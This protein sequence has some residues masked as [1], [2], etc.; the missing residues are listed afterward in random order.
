MTPLPVGFLRRGCAWRRRPAKTSVLF[1]RFAVVAGFT[2]ALPVGHVPK[3]F[4]V[5]SVRF[6]VIYHGGRCDPTLTVAF[7]TKRV[8]R[9]KYRTSPLPPGAITARRS[10]ASSVI[11]LLTNLSQVLLAIA[12]FAYQL[13]AVWVTTGSRSALCHECSKRTKK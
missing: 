3:R 7:G 2:K 5:A 8:V 4:L 10:I 12:W 6:D 11:P 1:D 9:Q 13:A